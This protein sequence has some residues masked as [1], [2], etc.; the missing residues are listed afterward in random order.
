[1]LPKVFGPVAT[2]F[3]ILLPAVAPAQ[4]P[5]AP[6]PL[7]MTAENVQGTDRRHRALAA[8][9]GGRIAT[10]PGDTLGYQLTFTNVRRDSVRNVQFTDPLPNG[11]QFAA[12]SAHADRPDVAIDYSIDGGTHYS[13]A[14]TISRQADGRTVQLPAPVTMYTNV[15]WTVRGWVQPG[16]QV[17]AAFSAVLAPATGAQE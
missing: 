1:M 11:L 3:A 13:A 16:A 17:V 14:P 5:R 8:E 15:R 4:V 10:L 2:L 9:H 7:T 6:T 12:G